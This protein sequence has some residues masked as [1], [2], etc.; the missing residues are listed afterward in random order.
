M[1][2]MMVVLSTGCMC[3]FL[4]YEWGIKDIQSTI[5]VLQQ[6]SLIFLLTGIPFPSAKSCII[7]EPIHA[8]INDP[9]PFIYT[10][11]C[12]MADQSM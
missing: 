6:T 3:V 8:V 12:I 2:Q 9:I 11:F 7:Y 1:L 10:W 5:I 4:G